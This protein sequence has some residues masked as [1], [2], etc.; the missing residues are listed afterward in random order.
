[1]NDLPIDQSVLAGALDGL[2]RR[3][4][5]VVVVHSSMIRFGRELT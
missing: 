4:S 1:M 5:R 3:N 2:L